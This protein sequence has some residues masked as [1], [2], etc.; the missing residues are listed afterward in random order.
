MITFSIAFDA[1]RGIVCARF[2]SQVSPTFAA[3][4]KQL[5]RLRHASG[6]ERKEVR[7]AIKE[8][9]ARLRLERKWEK[10][11]ERTMRMFIARVDAF[12]ARACPGLAKLS[13]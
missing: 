4:D 5:D 6:E 11:M 9:F 10:R 7:A 8:L 2:T 12:N 3:L 13:R 1:A